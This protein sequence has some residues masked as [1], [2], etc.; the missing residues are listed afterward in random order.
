MLARIGGAISARPVL[1]RW[2]LAGPV[3]LVL[4]VVT[5]AAMPFWVPAGPA[6]LDHLAFPILLFPLIWTITVLYPCMDEKLPRAVTIILGLT[7]VQTLLIISA[8]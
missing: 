2:I 8:F 4:A 7:I 5:M 1:T 6:N 3:A